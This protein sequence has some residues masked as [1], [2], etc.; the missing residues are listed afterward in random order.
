MF[1]LI[2]SACDK[3]T[4]LPRPGLHRDVNRFGHSAVVSNG[5][6][7]TPPPSP[8]V[9]LLR[10]VNFSWLFINVYSIS[11]FLQQIHTAGEL[12]STDPFRMNNSFPAFF[13]PLTFPWCLSVSSKF[14]NSQP[15]S[16]FSRRRCYPDSVWI[17]L[18][19][20]NLNVKFSVLCLLS[21]LPLLT[22][23]ML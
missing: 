7:F 17:V 20:F 16:G 8:T 15:V 5:W 18:S 1:A 22:S 14:Q 13:F 19:F 9:Y 6:A 2:S 4:V 10:M 21:F 23:L 11:Q 12:Y 3:W